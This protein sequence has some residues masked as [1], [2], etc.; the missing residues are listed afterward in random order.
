MLQGFPL[1]PEQASTTAVPWDH[2]FYFLTAVSIF[3]SVLIFAAIFYFAV[4]YRRR[5]KDEI[6]RQIEGH[7]GLELTWTLIP[8]GLCV[9]M[10]VWASGLFIKDSHPPAGS[11]EIFVVAKQWMWKCQHPEGPREINELHVPVG[12]PIK[13]TMTSEDVIHDFAV[14]AFR[15]KR[16]VV[17]GIYSSE[18]FEATR[19][20]RYHLFCDQYCGMGHSSMVGWIDVMSPDD[21]AHWL[22]SQTK[23]ESMPA[24]GA[25]LFA[26]LG[27]NSCH[28]AQGTEKGPSLQGIF[29]KQ[30]KLQSGE[31]VVADD[32]YLRS[33]ILDP[34]PVAGFPATMPTFQGQ[35]SEDEV[36]QLIAYMKSLGTAEER[37]GTK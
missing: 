5:S 10:F 14:P 6:P 27:C 24:R 3:F 22:D 33:S 15:I 32:A 23:T 13:L 36:L 29:G 1:Q 17:P 34:R 16:D 2:L 37:K 11:T 30:V 19:V 35:V 12:V 8:A 21:Y 18:W 28:V 25:K 31:T 20:G 9:V 7:L 4:K 26:Q